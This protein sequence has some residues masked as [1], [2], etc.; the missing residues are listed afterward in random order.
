MDKN[1]SNIVANKSNLKLVSEFDLLIKQIQYDIS[2]NVIPEKDKTKYQF[3]LR[4]F[5]N[6]LKILK[7][8]PDKIDSGSD[9]K[10]VSGIGKGTID[11]I[12]EILTNN[13]LSEIDTTKIQKVKKDLGL[14]DDLSK[15]INIGPK[16]AKQLID[17]YNIKSVEELKKKIKKGEIEVNDKIQ[18]GLK[19]YGIF[20][21][22]I[23]RAEIDKYYEIFKKLIK[24][25]KNSQSLGISLIIAGSYRREKKTSNDIDILITAK[26]I[27]SDKDYDKLDRNILT[28]FLTLLKSKKILVDNLTDFNNKTKYMGFSKLPRKP[29][30]R[31]DVRFVPY[32]SF[33][34]ALLYFTGSYDLNK[35]M[36][37][38]AKQKG[39]KL[40]EYGLYKL[41]ENGEPSTRKI[42]INSE[43][44]IFKKLGMDYLEPNQRG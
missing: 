36:R 32:D 35:D 10:D 27:T 7:Q 13:K 43:S 16:V 4:H 11:R 40:N 24:E 1:K 41:K 18:M 14:L 39:Y 15:V 31:I 8:Y 19:Y 21:E 38:I 25:L 22:N 3:K 12:D 33:H 6:A 20:K 37:V 2:N 9:L 34:S 23:P 30:R 5:K 29:V 44:D 26:N 28:D 17:K 42:K